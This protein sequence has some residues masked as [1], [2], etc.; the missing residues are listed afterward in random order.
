MNI[1][2]LN[3]EGTPG[4]I[5]YENDIQ[6][7][8]SDPYGF[9]DADEF[10]IYLPGATIAELP[11]GFLS[12]GHLGSKN[13]RETLPAGYY[14]IYNVGGEEGFVGIDDNNIWSGNYM[15]YYQGCKS[16]LWPSYSNVSHLLFWPESGAA[17]IDLQFI[18]SNDNQT[19]FDA[20]DSRGS[21]DYHISLDI[22]DDMSTV[23]VTV[24]SAN[25][26]DMSA[27]G[28]TSDG[29]FVAEYIDE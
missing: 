17:I 9:D 19:E 6:Y 4:S 15:Y 3:I 24:T 13:I 29:K 20:S 12:W 11:E 7:I 21:G 8:V 23:I 26:I 25:G 5:Y 1:E 18:W 22:S 16:A 2:T 27:W 10:Y 28:G 14:G